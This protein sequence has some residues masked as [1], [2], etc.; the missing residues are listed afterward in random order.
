[1]QR[2]FML[3]LI[4]SGTAALNAQ[5]QN[6]EPGL[7]EMT[8]SNAMAGQNLPDVK[9]LMANIPAEQRAMMEQMLQQKGISLGESG[10]IRVCLTE[11][12]IAKN[13]IPLSD[14][15]SGCQQTV[16]ERSDKQWKFTFSCPEGQG[17]GVVQ[18]ISSKEFT[19]QVDGQFKYEGVSQQGT[20]KTHGTWVQSNCG[21][22]K[23]Q[24]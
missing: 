19:T 10:G 17:S 18:F 11:Q 3:A 4:L 12:Q 22:V 1:M 14:P 16:T 2:N 9:T 24:G 21:S 7:W 8:S 23:P 6:I 5:A 15:E 13:D 20:M